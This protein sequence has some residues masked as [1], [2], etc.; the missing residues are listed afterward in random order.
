MTAAPH[1]S[2][3]S[4]KSGGRPASA[5]TSV[6]LRSEPSMRRLYAYMQDTSRSSSRLSLLQAAVFL[7][8]EHDRLQNFLSQF[9]EYPGDTDIMANVEPQTLPSSKQQRPVPPPLRHKLLPTVPLAY[10]SDPSSSDRMYTISGSID[11]T[12]KYR[13]GSPGPLEALPLVNKHARPIDRYTRLVAPVKTI[14]SNNGL[15][16]ESFGLVHRHAPHEQ[17]DPWGRD[18]TIFVET[19]AHEA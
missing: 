13:Q 14:L 2:E 1:A 7:S 4:C 6:E 3:M 8:S 10:R 15:L 11:T 17:P 12:C 18:L 19:P 5:S 9:I 16:Y